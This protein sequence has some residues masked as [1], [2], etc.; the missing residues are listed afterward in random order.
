[1]IMGER[2]WQTTRVPMAPWSSMML[3]GKYSSTLSPL[4]RHNALL[5]AKET[6]GRSQV[7]GLIECLMRRT[8][9]IMNNE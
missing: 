3:V 9:L 5:P 1:M 8:L 4:V 2:V 6:V 7:S